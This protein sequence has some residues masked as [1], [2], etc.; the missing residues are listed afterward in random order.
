MSFFVSSSAT[1]NAEDTGVFWQGLNEVN[2]VAQQGESKKYAA[3]KL[4]SSKNGLKNTDATTLGSLEGLVDDGLKKRFQHSFF[5]YE[6]S[7]SQPGCQ[8]NIKRIVMTDSILIDPKSYN[9]VK[10]KVLD[11]FTWKENNRMPVNQGTGTMKNSYTVYKHIDTTS[12]A[13]CPT[14]EIL[15]KYTDPDYKKQLSSGE[16]KNYLE[17][18]KNANDMETKYSNAYKNFQST[19]DEQKA[20]DKAP[21]SKG[22]KFNREVLMTTNMHHVHKIPKKLVGKI[23]SN[24]SPKQM[25][26]VA[27]GSSNNNLQITYLGKNKEDYTLNRL[28][29]EGLDKD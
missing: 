8:D 3:V 5:Y 2:F 10:E 24:E 16:M 13:S 18:M 23:F 29:E 27:F 25:K 6:G 12:R 22:V 17:L 26:S 11:G 21:V 28:V 9:N 14:R 4:D 1:V 20:E 19:I 7:L 15:K